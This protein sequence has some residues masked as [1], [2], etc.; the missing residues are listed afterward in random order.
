M[1]STVSDV[2]IPLRRTQ[3]SRSAETR[4]RVL[5]ATTACLVEHGYA[6]TTTAAVQARAGVSRGALMHHFGSKNELLVAAVR[7][8]AARRGAN[9]IEQANALD[10]DDHDDRTSQAID[11]LWG[12]F[13][14]PLFT[15]TLELWAAS[16]TDAELRAAVLEF[17][18]ALR[19]ELDIAMRRLFGSAVADSPAF[20]DAIEFTL[21]FM[22]GAA[23]TSILRTDLHRQRAVIDR[24]KLVFT[25]LIEERASLAVRQKS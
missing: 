15:A 9:L 11:L 18:R 12:T 22:R 5:E 7:H 25:A 17:E 10:D 3:E 8:L 20:A 23:L 1:L 24:W 14:G 16:R 2:S 21:Q 4:L 19:R 6:G 13:T